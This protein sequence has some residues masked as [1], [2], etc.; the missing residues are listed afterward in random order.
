[1]K[2][3]I[4]I[5][6]FVPFMTMAQEFGLNGYEIIEDWKELSIDRPRVIMENIEEVE[7]FRSIADQYVYEFAFVNTVNYDLVLE[8]CK[9]F[10]ERH[11]GSF[12]YP[13]MNTSTVSDLH[14]SFQS[15]QEVNDGESV[16]IKWLMNIEGIHTVVIFL[17]GPTEYSETPVVSFIMDFNKEF[18]DL[19]ETTSKS[20]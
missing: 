5:L 12:K 1:M 4:S 2:K 13:Y 6:A 3:A 14:N 16:Y 15:A 20:E 8:E 10:I 9:A 18:I 17:A 19:P 7:H 11:G